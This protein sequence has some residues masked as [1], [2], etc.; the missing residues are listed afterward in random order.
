MTQEQPEDEDGSQEFP[1][2]E[3]DFPVMKIE[4]LGGGG[5]A[6]GAL[7]WDEAGRKTSPRGEYVR[8]DIDRA[9]RED[10]ALLLATTVR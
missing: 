2:D 4:S 5:M 7:G 3:E 8:D 1:E 10:D 6:A 9:I